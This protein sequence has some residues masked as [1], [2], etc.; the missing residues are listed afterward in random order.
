MEKRFIPH[1][2]IEKADSP[3][4]NNDN[5]LWW[6]QKKLCFQNIGSQK[7]LTL[8]ANQFFWNKKM[9]TKLLSFVISNNH[10]IGIDWMAGNKAI[11][12]GILHNFMKKGAAKQ[13]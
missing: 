11:Y 12:F 4:G 6:G 9:Y 2:A 13:T 10:Q 5:I 1:L 7:N 8:V 3:K